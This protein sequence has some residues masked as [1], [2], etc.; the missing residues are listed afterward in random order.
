MGEEE[1]EEDEQEDEEG[2]ADELGEEGGDV[3][4]GEVEVAEVESTAP[5]K[6]GTAEEESLTD[7][8]EDLVMRFGLGP[9]WPV[10]ESPYLRPEAPPWRDHPQSIPGR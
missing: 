1:A 5:V 7:E 10:L 3:V 6:T 8:V 2:A 9:Q 4:A